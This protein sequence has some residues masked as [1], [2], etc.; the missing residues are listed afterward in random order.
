MKNWNERCP[1]VLDPPVVS[2][3]DE[4]FICFVFIGAEPGPPGRLPNYMGTEDPRNHWEHVH[5]E[6][7]QRKINLI[8]GQELINSS[9][10]T[11]KLLD[12]FCFLMCS[13]SMI[14]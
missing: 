2:L 3:T 6:Q 1:A 9:L 7:T 12:V 10:C 4:V 5:H 14:V 11:K 8:A 13:T